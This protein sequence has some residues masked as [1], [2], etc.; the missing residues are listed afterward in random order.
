MAS[1]TSSVSVCCCRYA[2]TFRKWRE[3]GSGLSQQRLRQQENRNRATT[4]RRR[5]LRWRP[6]TTSLLV[7]CKLFGYLLLLLLLFLRSA[8]YGFALLLHSALSSAVC[9]RILNVCVSVCLC[10]QDH[11]KKR[12]REITESRYCS[13]VTL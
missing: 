2:L 4:L 9:R 5:R 3:R 10:K 8:F 7:L 13:V 11:D 12:E 1:Q 6:M